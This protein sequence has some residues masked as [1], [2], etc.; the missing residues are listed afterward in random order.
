MENYFQLVWMYQT[1]CKLQINAKIYTYFSGFQL[2]LVKNTRIVRNYVNNILQF[3]WNCIDYILKCEFLI[4]YIIFSYI[5]QSVDSFIYWVWFM[6][7]LNT[8]IHYI[9]ILFILFES[10]F[11]LFKIMLFIF[12]LHC[13]LFLLKNGIFRVTERLLQWIWRRC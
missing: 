11:K 8:F 13:V 4:L 7:Y 12:F 10:I 1:C 3:W 6:I 9:L 2:Y 5:F